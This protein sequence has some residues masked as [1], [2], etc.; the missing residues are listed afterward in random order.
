M[1]QSLKEKT[2]LFTGASRGI[3]RAIAERLAKDGATV[4]LTYNAAS[5]AQTRQSRPSRKP[6]ALRSRSTRTSPT[7]Q[8]SRPCSKDSMTS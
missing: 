4:A 6:E 8:P 3:G 7:L 1:A 2:A 5:Q